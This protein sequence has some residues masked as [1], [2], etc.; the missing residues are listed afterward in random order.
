M[1]KQQA[2]KCESSELQVGSINK[3]LKQ[4]N[5]IHKPTQL[6]LTEIIPQSFQTN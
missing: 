3:H 6:I 5:I 1:H 2:D 4:F